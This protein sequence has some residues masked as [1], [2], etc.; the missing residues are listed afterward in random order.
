[1]RKSLGILFLALIS[2]ACKENPYAQLDGIISAREEIAANLKHKTDSIRQ[3]FY[4]SGDDSLRFAAAEA[5]YSEWRHLNL[6]SSIFWAGQ[7]RK[8]AGSDEAR[9][10]STGCADVR[11]FI[12]SDRLEEAKRLFSSLSLP[13]DAST[14][15]TDLYYYT[16]NRLFSQI[17]A[18]ES[19]TMEPSLKML[20]EQ[21]LSGNGTPYKAL[22][23]KVKYLRYDKRDSEA[24]S[25]LKS[26]PVSEID[27]ASKATYY[28]HFSSLYYS[29]GDYTACKDYALKAAFYDLSTGMRDYFSLYLLSQMLFR[30]GEWKRA[31]RY[32]NIAINDALAYNY[33]LGLRRSARA[34]VIMDDAIKQINRRNGILLWGGILIVSFFLAVALLLLSLNRRMLRKVTLAN[35]RYEESQQA[36]RSVSNIK[37]KMLGEYMELSSHYIYKVDENK[38]HY[39]KVLKES[40]PDALMAMFRQPA[41]ADLEYPRY[42]ENFDKIFLGIFPDFVS[43]VNALMPAEHAFICEV[44]GSL[45]TQLRILALIRLGISESERIAV[46]LHI[47]KGTV[48]TYRSVMRNASLSPD[49]FEEEVLMISDV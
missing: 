13:E 45:T 11:I 29:E 18:E 20:S 35:R 6:D 23:F 21:Y 12:R 40:G 46:I 26:I 27:D 32:M 36:L 24:L 38:S 5:L 39:R 16:A 17:P 10:L 22:M 34:A 48:Y 7:M 3:V 44:P 42:W 25:L 49:T 28:M 43:R 33:P 47:S 14:G 9:L 31:S 2:F 1:M 30:E 41:F 8:Y 37:D 4:T 19:E 15:Q